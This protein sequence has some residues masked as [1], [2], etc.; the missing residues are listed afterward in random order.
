MQTITARRLLSGAVMGKYTK[1]MRITMSFKKLLL[2][3][4]AVLTVFAL[5]G[6]DGRDGNTSGSAE[7]NG[8]I[9][10][11]SRDHTSKD[12]GDHVSDLI[13]DVESGAEDIVSDAA[14]AVSDLVD[15]K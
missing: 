15:G 1:G 11:D 8:M 13:S 14:S 3:L 2:L 7:S 4:L 10:D 6:C 5:A 12:L 9:S